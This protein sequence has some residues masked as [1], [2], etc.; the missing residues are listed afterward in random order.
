MRA[1]VWRA[2]VE[3][4]TCSGTKESSVRTTS[5]G[6][7]CALA[8]GVLLG[9]A[10]AL[11]SRRMEAHLLWT[12]LQSTVSAIVLAVL[13]PVRS[14]VWELDMWGLPL[15]R[16]SGHESAQENRDGYGRGAEAEL[17]FAAL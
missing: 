14:Q 13:A 10:L 11:C 2:K 1:G 5:W 17:G 8:L 7:V 15:H 4:N 12:A 16:G 6:T 3:G 9:G